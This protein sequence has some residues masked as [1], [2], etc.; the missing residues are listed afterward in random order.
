MSKLQI[1]FLGA[2]VWVPIG[3]L[4]CYFL[5]WLASQTLD[6]PG[7]VLMT[8]LTINEAKAIAQKHK[9]QGVVILSFDMIE[10]KYAGVSY[11]VTKAECKVMGTLLDNVATQLSEGKLKF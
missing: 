2:L 4:T 3:Y 9:A 7:S 1:F 11:G 8:N 10:G 6:K 5:T